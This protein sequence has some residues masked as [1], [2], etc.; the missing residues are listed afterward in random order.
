M[1]IKFISELQPKA[2][3]ALLD[4]LYLRGSFRI[5]ATLTDRN[6]LDSD[7][8]KQGMKVYV[9]S[10]DTVYELQ[11]NLT[12][13]I[14]DRSLT[15]T[16]QEAYNNGE[17]IIVVDEKPFTI[18]NSDE[19]IF[20]VSANKLVQFYDTLK[21]KDYTSNITVN[22]ITSS[23][24]IIIDETD[25]TKYRAVQYFYTITNS[26]VSGFETGQLYII[27]DGTDCSVYQIL[28][29]SIGIPCGVSFSVTI[30]DNSLN[31]LATSDDSGPFSRIAHLFKVA[32]I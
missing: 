2:N 3:F 21:G 10:T 17:I 13:W 5:C 7:F 26:D 18:S 9:Q 15:T 1:P 32:L 12:T 4:D 20:K 24:D 6:N 22:V 8:L 28:G 19:E 14:V 30:V 27:H 25:K 16:L 23:T 29:N 11:S 31:L